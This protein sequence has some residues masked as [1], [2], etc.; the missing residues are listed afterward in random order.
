MF[1][2]CCTILPLI[3]DESLTCMFCNTLKF[4][5]KL[6]EIFENISN[7]HLVME[8]RDRINIKPNPNLLI[9]HLFTRFNHIQQKMICTTHNSNSSNGTGTVSSKRIH[10]CKSLCGVATQ[11]YQYKITSMSYLF[12]VKITVRIAA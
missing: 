8:G 12:I 6:C 5:H 2:Q 9:Q 3:T 11:Y 7:F 10:Q 4:E 1:I